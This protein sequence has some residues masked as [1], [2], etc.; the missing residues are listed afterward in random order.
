[1]WSIKD[2]CVRN[3]KG[4][5]HKTIQDKRGLIRKNY[6]NEVMRQ[7]MSDFNTLLGYDD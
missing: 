3:D 2:G 6:F 4:E 1:V 5:P 7:V